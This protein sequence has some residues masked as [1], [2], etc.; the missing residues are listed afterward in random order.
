MRYKEIHGLYEYCIKIGIEATI[1]KMF[2]GYAI[3]FNNGG[4]FV[5]HFGSY[6]CNVGCVEPAI[7]CRLD[8]SAVPLEKAKSLVRYHKDKLNKCEKGEI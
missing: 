7:G 3:R 4:D 6:G 1:S 2:D 5:Q 8:Y